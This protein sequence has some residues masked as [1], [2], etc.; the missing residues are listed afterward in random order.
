[1]K[2]HILTIGLAAVISALAFVPATAL[3][4]P[5]SVNHTTYVFSLGPLPLVP[6]IR[7]PDIALAPNGSVIIMAG[8]GQFNAGPDK[9]VSGGGP[10]QICSAYSGNPTSPCAGSVRASG[11]WTATQMLSFVNY[12]SGAVQG[13]PPFTYGGQAQMVV[14][15]SHVG[16]GVL[17]IDCTLG[18]PPPGH[19]G[20]G[21]NEEG[22]DLRLG[23]GLTF[24]REVFGDTLFINPAQ[25]P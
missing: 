19:T 22:I 14:S 16:S 6:F 13:L 25:V 7:G 1:M 9:S 12:G 21:T 3:A 5:A 2:R 23:N 4:A 18:I 20:P 8:V 24:N 10:F 15:L 17:N 11:T